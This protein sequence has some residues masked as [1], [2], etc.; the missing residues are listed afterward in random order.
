MSGLVTREVCRTCGVYRHLHPIA[1]CE[2]ARLSW[3]WHRHLLS[4]HIV[5]F[6][7]VHVVPSKARIR[8][9]QHLANKGRCWCDLVDSFLRANLWD[10]W[11]S[12]YSGEWGCL[13]DFPLPW[14]ATAPTPGRCYCTTAAEVSR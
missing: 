2:R 11:K 9:C 7:W 6:L 10:D 8:Y 12:D 5:A 3:W 14:D 4:R 1:R 13:C